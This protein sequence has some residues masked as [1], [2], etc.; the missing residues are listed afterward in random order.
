MACEIGVVRGALAVLASSVVVSD[1]FEVRLEA[2][3]ALVS[4]DDLG[5][6]SVQ[7]ATLLEQQHVVDDVL[8][9]RVLEAVEERAAGHHMSRRLQARETLVNGL[10]FV[11]Q[12]RKKLHR[13]LTADHGRE[14]EQLLV[15][16]RQT[17]DARPDDGLNVGGG[18]QLS[19]DVVAFSRCVAQGLKH[20]FDE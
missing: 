19:T 9:D 15:R 7:G 5:D 6:P 4:L 13:E 14:L 1:R 10:S 17:I 18:V 3:L 20:L 2:A 12:N 8:H 16:A 11:V